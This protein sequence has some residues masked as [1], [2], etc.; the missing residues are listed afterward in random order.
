[1]TVSPDDKLTDDRF[2]GGALSVLQPAAGYRAGLD[3]VLLAAAARGQMAAG[4]RVLDAGAGVGVVGLAIAAGVA[5][6]QVTL[7]EIDPALAE[8]ARRNAERNGLG[9][10]VRVAVADIAGGGYILHA[11]ETESVLT[12]ANFDHVVTNPPFYE[13]GSGTTS[14]HR[15]KAAAHQMQTGGL[16]RWIAFLATAATSDGTL[17]MIHRADTVGAVLATLQGRFGRIRI[18]PV[19]SRSDAPAGRILVTAIKGSRAALELRPALILQDASG[20]YLPDVED[21]LRH[22]AAIAV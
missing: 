6:V 8:L 18:R 12:P 9:D 17:T 11:A 1:M 5:G 15:I 10:R 16:D 2:L 20:R 14:P 22:G 4:G 7:V 13:I 21:V 3:A 19:H